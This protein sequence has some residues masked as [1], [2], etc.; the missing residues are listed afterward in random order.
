LA[1]IWARSLIRELNDQLTWSQEDGLDDR[2]LKTALAYNL[3][4]AYTSFVAV[5]SSIVTEGDYGTTVHVPVPMPA[6]VR[7]DTTVDGGG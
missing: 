1:Q 4:S 6:G 5:D 7:Y 2:I 3:A